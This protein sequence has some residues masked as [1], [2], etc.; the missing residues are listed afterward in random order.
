MSAGWSPKIIISHA[1]PNFSKMQSKVDSMYQDQIRM[2]QLVE[3]IFVQPD[4]KG[5]RT[6]VGNIRIKATD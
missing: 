2:F 5:K 6:P 1:P 3:E 4:G